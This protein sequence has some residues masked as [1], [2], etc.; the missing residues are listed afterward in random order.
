VDLQVRYV[1][2]EQA[3]QAID[4]VQIKFKRMP[5]VR[6]PAYR[7]DAH[8]QPSSVTVV[9]HMSASAK[10][11]LS[12]Q[13]G[14]AVDAILPILERLGVRSMAD[15]S[16]LSE[17]DLVKAGV[18]L[19]LARLLSQQA[20]GAR[21]APATSDAESRTASAPKPIVRADPVSVTRATSAAIPTGLE[22]EFQLMDCPI[23]SIC[24]ICRKKDLDAMGEMQKYRLVCD[25][26]Q[27]HFSKVG[28]STIATHWK[29][30]MSDA[31][32]RSRAG[33]GVRPPG[34]FR[35]VVEGL[36]FYNEYEYIF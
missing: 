20:P 32:C 27:G 19:V 1:G 22:Q 8:H 26:S 4:D 33:V 7:P 28:N 16:V 2:F 29:V 34:D 12:S 21:V 5:R 14:G 9:H 15:L 6:A 35:Q 36:L 18:P 3:V 30:P 25:S 17:R 13:M 23:K 24:P 31:E 11:A 10:A